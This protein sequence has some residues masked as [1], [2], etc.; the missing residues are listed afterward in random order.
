MTLVTASW[1]NLAG[2]TRGRFCE[3][4]A[5]LNPKDDTGLVF[6][7]HD[8]TP[9]FIPP[10]QKQQEDQ[11]RRRMYLSGEARTQGF[12]GELRPR[13]PDS[14]GRVFHPTPFGHSVIATFVLSAIE[15]ARA[16]KLGCP[17][18]VGTENLP[19][20]E[21]KNTGGTRNTVACGK[22]SDLYTSPSDIGAAIDKYYA[23]H[24]ENFFPGDMAGPNTMNGGSGSHILTQGTSVKSEAM[25]FY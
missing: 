1:D 8:N 18:D 4:G 15:V 20:E 23:H 10:E 22:C 5:S 3:E 19:G 24:G 21:A 6:Q 17:H 2:A 13:V 7:R 9:Q 25:S 16:E 14:I 11:V 12:N